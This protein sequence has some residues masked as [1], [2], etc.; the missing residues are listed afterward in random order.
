MDTASL[1]TLY[2]EALQTQYKGYGPLLAMPITVLMLYINAVQ[3]CVVA[4]A[5][6]AAPS[7]LVLQLFGGALQEYWLH[8]L[9][10]DRDKGDQ[11]V[12][13]CVLLLKDR[14]DIHPFLWFRNF[15]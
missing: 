1:K 3:G 13:P 10:G 15:P 5:V 7:N 11:P 2:P 14:S 8:H 12:V 9:P 6:L 4:K